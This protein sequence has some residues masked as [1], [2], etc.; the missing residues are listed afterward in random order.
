MTRRAV[1]FAAT[2]LFLLLGGAWWLAAAGDTG[3]VTLDVNG[4]SRAFVVYEPK[5][6][7]PDRNL[8]LVIVLHGGGGNPERMQHLTKGRF[9]ALADLDQF[10]VVYPE[11]V[12]G[13][14]NDGRNVEAIPAQRPPEP[15]APF[16]QSPEMAAGRPQAAK[17]APPAG[18]VDDV[19]FISA[20]IDFLVDKRK[21]DPHRVYATGISNGAMMVNRLGCELSEKIAAIAP[22]AGQLPYNLEAS[23]RPAKVVSVLTI[24]GDQ[25]PLVPF[26][27]GEIRLWRFGR[28]R[29]NVLSTEATMKLWADRAGCLP[30]P[31]VMHEAPRV[32]DDGTKMR[33]EEFRGCREG[34]AVTLYVIEGGGHAWP[35][36]VQ[37]LPE[38]F[39]GRASGQLDA[40]E[41]IWHFFR[42]HQR[43]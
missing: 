11:G 37:Y 35:G 30:S 15:F 42:S 33:R 4:R 43:S 36:G 39:V 32:P 26:D 19:A 6:Q 2:A 18:P 40:A 23:C 22:V 31:F 8:P 29:G 3:T 24:N 34:A 27:G 9:N 25:D 5:R 7:L 10:V 12:G 21:V 14:W 41:A 13:S 16:A 17:V 28:G 1:L 38:R 20:M